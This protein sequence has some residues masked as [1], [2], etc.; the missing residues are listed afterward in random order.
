MVITNRASRTIWSN[1]RSTYVI[2]PFFFST[3][4]A[5][6]LY[7]RPKIDKPS[8]NRKKCLKI[9]PK[10]TNLPGLLHRG[11]GRILTAYIFYHNTMESERC[12]KKLIFISLFTQW[13][14]ISEEHE[15]FHTCFNNFLISVYYLTVLWAPTTVKTRK[16]EFAS[17]PTW[18]LS[19]RNIFIYFHA[20][21]KLRAYSFR[22]S[23]S[24]E[25]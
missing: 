4:P 10:I 22:I 24:S 25:F 13:P 15:L 18:S 12:Q 2:G 19:G 14:Y 5:N 1:A 20:I 23:E 16:A 7:V 3:N 21:N 17:D 8:Q 11:V 6:F 9:R